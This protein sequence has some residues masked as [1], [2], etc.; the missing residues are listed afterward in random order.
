ML[1]PALLRLSLCRGLTCLGVLLLGTCCLPAEDVNGDGLADFWVNRYGVSAFS[2]S[3]DPDGDGRPNL[4]ESVNWTDPN[5]AAHPDAG[6]G[7]VHIRDLDG[8]KLDDYWE[9]K[10]LRNATPLLPY[11]DEDGDL[12]TN[13]EES[14]VGTDPWV[15]D[16][17]WRSLGGPVVTTGPGSFTLN[18][19]GIAGQSYLIQKSTDMVTWLD[20]TQAWG[21]GLEKVVT[22]DTGTETRMFFRILLQQTNGSSL[23][24]DGDGLSDWYELFVF[25]TNPYD[26]DSDDDGM[27]DGWEAAYGLNLKSGLDALTDGDGDGIGNVDEF[28]FQLDPRHDDFS[29]MAHVVTFDTADRV[30]SLDGPGVGGISYTYD[31]EGNL[32][33]SN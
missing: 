13:M 10:H 31:A 24:S 4:V 33:T 7:M 17:P 14:V 25:G 29:E 23:D 5:D 16:T 11:D 18:F 21:S 2:G 19:R 30:K 8:N 22:I 15:Q 28:T 3:A 27:P 26:A 1:R 12:R 6:W 9:A 32:L 20:H